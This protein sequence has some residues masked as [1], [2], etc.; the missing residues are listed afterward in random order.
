MV[1]V[2]QRLLLTGQDVSGADGMVPRWLVREYGRFRDRLLDPEYPCYFGTSA[3]KRGELRYGYVEGDDVGHVP[4]LL[5]EFLALSKANP[6]VRHALALFFE[7]E[8]ARRPLS[9]YEERF[10][11]VLRFLHGLDESPWPEDRPYDPVD[12][13]WEFCFAGEPMF[14][15]ASAP[16]YRL[17]DSRNMGDSLV[18]L[19]QPR[20]VFDGI[21]GGTPAGT[22]AREIIRARMEAWEGM[23]AHPDMGSYGDPS[24]HEWK[25]YFLPD[26]NTPVTGRCPFHAATDRAVTRGG[27][28]GERT[29]AREKGDRRE[30]AMTQEAGRR[31][32]I[33]RGGGVELEMAVMELLPETGSVE[34]QRDTPGREHETHTH[35]TD[36][37]LLIVDGSITFRYDDEEAA[38]TSGDRLLLPEG[39]K[40]S[41]VAGEEGCVYVI[42]LETVA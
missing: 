39:T 20:R 17:R 32:E 18:L 23:E 14:V 31:P 6:Q 7:P 24:S 2:E 5:R 35:P 26:D 19:F 36:E 8:R 16:A 28:A 3:E 40:H 15:F 27:L 9:F 21:E 25:Q 30:D 4:A 12:P 1:K 34:V 22:R 37:T 41:S 29:R 42:A 11:Y 10:W 13:K 33:V 38:C